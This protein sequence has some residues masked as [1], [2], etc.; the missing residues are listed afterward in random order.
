MNNSES[1]YFNTARKMDEALLELLNEGNDLEYISVKQICALAGV[2]R[3]TFY[4][5]YRTI[6]D[7]LDETGE[8]IGEK[9]S[10]YFSKKQVENLDPGTMDDEEL[11]FIKPE[12]LIPYLTFV[13]ENKRLYQTILRIRHKLPPMQFAVKIENSIDTA[14]KRLIPEKEERKYLTSYYVGGIMSV[15]ETW[16][17]NDC[18]EDIEYISDLIMRC[19]PG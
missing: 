15:I 1:K 12:Y 6:E 3:S 2:N 19:I 13:R 8:Y 14:S 9:F 7:L 18:K 4:L 16:M 11:H 17:K 5:H 10:S